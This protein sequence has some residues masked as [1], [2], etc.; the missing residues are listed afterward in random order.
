MSNMCRMFKPYGF[1]YSQG[2]EYL[3]LK[4]QPE[5]HDS[6]WRDGD[7]QFFVAQKCAERYFS[8]RVITNNFLFQ[9][10]ANLP[11]IQV[12]NVSEE[13]GCE[14]DDLLSSEE[15]WQMAQPA[16]D[17]AWEVEDW[18]PLTEVEFT[19]PDPIEPDWQD[20]LPDEAFLAP[21][22]F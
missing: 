1:L 19:G 16:P 21:D 22:E 10:D 14:V 8:T 6:I 17:D 3:L 12:E 5:P 20:D 2:R 11:V 7:H 18:Q 9:Y 13:G 4:P 15:M